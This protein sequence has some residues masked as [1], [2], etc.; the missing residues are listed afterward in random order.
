MRT[1]ARVD[2]NQ[3]A[4]V[5][6]LRSVPG[7]KVLILSMVGKGCPDIMVGYQRKNFL[8]EIKDGDKPPSRRKLTP[9][10]KKF[11]KQWAGQVDTALTFED[12]LR[13]IGIEVYDEEEIPF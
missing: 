1:V 8:I 4:I 9:D 5:K 7:C 12:C 3:P 13:I 2:S 10:E 11:H 6:Q